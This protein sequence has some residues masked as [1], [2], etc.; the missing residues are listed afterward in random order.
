LPSS[1]ATSK[2]VPLQQEK[3]MPWSPA[4]R[5]GVAVTALASS[6]ASLTAQTIEDGLM[7]S[8]RSLCTGLLYTHESWDQYWEGALK[9]SN[10]NVGTVTTESVTWMGTYGITP[11]LNVIASLPYV[12]T[13]AS[14]GVLHRMTGLQDLTLAAKYNLL[15]TDFTRA[16]SLRALLVG[17]VATP[18][19]D[20]TP[21]FLPLSIGSASRRLSGRFTLHFQ[22]RRGWFV[23]GTTAYTRRGNVTLDRTSYF[24]DGRLYLS[25]EVALP[26]VFDYAVTAGYA[27]A[28]LQIPV[29]F[30]QQRT[31]GGG[32]I[33]RQDA[34]FVSNR[35]NFSKVNA[36]VHFSLPKVRN[37]ALRT[38]ATYVVEGRNVGQ[39]TA[40]TAGLLYT[41]RF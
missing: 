34:P 25:N 1:D 13:G 23:D 10:G 30:S 4:V 28:G 18:V 20:Y 8:S 40:I 12:W 17:S 37:L 3:N 31:L 26:D 41:F 39:A 6:A 35:M 16:G 22:A 5:I 15:E 21:D 7:M 24:T 2:I 11:R 36:V 29:S 38:A 9:R 33:R 32:D 14:Q 19:S 27:K